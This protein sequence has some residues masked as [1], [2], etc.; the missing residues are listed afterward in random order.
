MGILQVRPRLEAGETLRWK[1]LA[2]RV[3]SPAVTSGGRLVVTDRRV[4]FQPNRYDMMLGREVWERPLDVVTSVEVVGRDAAVF[5][6]GMRRRL[7]IRTADGL[8][9][10]VVNRLKKKVP[11]LRA[12]LPRAG[13]AQ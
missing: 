13:V 8:E 7:G 2:N 1:A 3:L 5:A 10:F 6:A 4:L 11:E 9:V 12:L